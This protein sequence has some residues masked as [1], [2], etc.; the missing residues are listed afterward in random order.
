MNRYKAFYRG[1]THEL[2]ADTS[3]KAQCLAAEHFKVNPKKAYNVTVV[4]LSVGE[5]EVV[6][7]PQD[8]CS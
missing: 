3:Y 1:N 8:L 6:H 2:D 5:R 4:L 7:K